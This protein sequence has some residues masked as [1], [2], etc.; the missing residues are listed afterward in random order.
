MYGITVIYYKWKGS[1]LASKIIFIMSL[2]FM[3]SSVYFKCVLG[4]VH[5]IVRDQRILQCVEASF[6]P[7]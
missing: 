4:D 6:P 1:W 7:N 2:F 5:G 3:P